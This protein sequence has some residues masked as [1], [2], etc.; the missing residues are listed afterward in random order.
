M[1]L[2]YEGDGVRLGW[3][4]VG[5]RRPGCAGVGLVEGWGSGG[6]G[7]P[8]GAGKAGRARG[9][10]AIEFDAISDDLWHDGGIDR[11]GLSC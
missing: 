5:L 9:P 6:W 11:G 1:E 2:G 4:L 8:G 3:R 7:L 10:I